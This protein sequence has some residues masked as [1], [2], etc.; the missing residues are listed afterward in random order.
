VLCR[1]GDR[2]TETERAKKIAAR[3]E[4]VLREQNRAD[5]QFNGLPALIENSQGALLVRIKQTT[6][7]SRFFED[8]G[9]KNPEVAATISAEMVVPCVLL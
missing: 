6:F 3:L 2:E 4:H 9:G 7:E 5:R 1:G 8:G